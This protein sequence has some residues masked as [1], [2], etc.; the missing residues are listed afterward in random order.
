[1]EGDPERGGGEERVVGSG[2]ADGGGRCDVL[3]Q[4]SERLC[5]DETFDAFAAV[6]QAQITPIVAGAGR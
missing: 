5:A 3:D 6:V 4:Q 2:C 1:V